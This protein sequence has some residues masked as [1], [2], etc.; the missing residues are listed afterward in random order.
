MKTRIISKI[1][2]GKARI[3]WRENNI[4]RMLFEFLIISNNK[5]SQ[6]QFYYHHLA[7]ITV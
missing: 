2:P 3:K 7:E 4:Y 5:Y 6:K 1:N